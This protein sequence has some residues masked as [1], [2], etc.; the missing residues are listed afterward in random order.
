[1]DILDY[2]CSVDAI[3]YQNASIIKY[4]ETKYCV[5]IR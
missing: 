3:V 5:H 1:M 2:T 4:Y